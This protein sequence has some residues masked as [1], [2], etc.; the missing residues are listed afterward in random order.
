MLEQSIR[1]HYQQ[2]LV[3]PIAKRVPR[4][5]TPI[6]ITFAAGIFGLGFIPALLLEKSTLAIG[7][8]LL[9]GYCDTLDGTIARLHNSSSSIG[10]VVD[11]MMDRFVEICAILGLYFVSP[12]TRALT[13]IFLLASILLCITSFLVVAIFTPNESAKSFHYSPGI[14]ERAE[15]FAFFIMMILVPEHY[16][17]LAVLLTVLIAVTTTIRLN[18]FIRATRHNKL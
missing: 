12:Q 17:S 7:L 1:H 15:T 11:I 14:I 3:D 5:V 10:T 2:L 4:S 9:S 8:L 16:N 6:H 13:T 18:Q